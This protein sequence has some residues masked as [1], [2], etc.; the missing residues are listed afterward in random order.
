MSNQ[1]IKKEK[2]ELKYPVCLIEDIIHQDFAVRPYPPYHLLKI[3][4]QRLQGTEKNKGKK[5]CASKAD[6]KHIQTQIMN[7]IQTNGSA[8][9]AASQSSFF[10]Q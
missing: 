8:E 3:R 7:G 6:A 5:T 1:T 9:N 4:I 2:K 10:P